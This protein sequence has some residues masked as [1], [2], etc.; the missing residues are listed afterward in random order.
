MG[1]DKPE[2][3]PPLEYLGCTS[4]AFGDRAGSSSVTVVEPLCSADADDD[5]RGSDELGSS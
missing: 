2:D 1:R 5:A 4:Y 3:F